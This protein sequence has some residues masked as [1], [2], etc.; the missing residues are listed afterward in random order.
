MKAAA[1]WKAEET[2]AKESGEFDIKKAMSGMESDPLKWLLYGN[3]RTM[4]VIWT[5]K[6]GE[7]KKQTKYHLTN[8]SIRTLLRVLATTGK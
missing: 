7:K 5:T 6:T 4:F 8:T 1:A 3:D 2:R